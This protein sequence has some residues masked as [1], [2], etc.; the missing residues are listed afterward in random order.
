MVNRIYYFKKYFKPR[1]FDFKGILQHFKFENWRIP[2]L[3]SRTGQWLRP[4]NVHEHSG[5]FSIA[6]SKKQKRPKMGCLS[7]PHN[8]L[9]YLFFLCKAYL[10]TF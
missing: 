2:F 5:T 6:I 3:M 9:T 7:L 8:L 4:S 1:F 10:C